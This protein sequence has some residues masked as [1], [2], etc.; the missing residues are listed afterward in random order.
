MSPAGASDRTQDSLGT[1]C[2]IHDTATREDSGR[3]PITP[4]AGRWR[5]TIPSISRWTAPSFGRKDEGIDTGT[6]IF[7]S[8][9]D[10]VEIRRIT[11]INR[12]VYAR[13]LALTSYVELA[14]A[15][16]NADLQHPAFQKIFIQTEAI[17][18]LSTL[19]A[20]RRPRSPEEPPM[21]VAHRFA[22]TQPGRRP[23]AI[24]NRPAPLHRAGKDTGQSDG[25]CATG[26]KQPGLR[27]GSHPEPPGKRGPGAGP[28][29]AAVPGHRRRRIARESPF[30]GGEVLAILSPSTGRWILT[31]P[32][33]SSNCGPCGSNPT[34]PAN[35]RSWPTIFC[36]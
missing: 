5:T 16:H 23:D 9:E 7:V 4:S 13:K 6:E 25:A 1:F 21:F 32:P 12:T 30:P 18:P 15:P 22:T 31:G 20:F 34:M 35:F 10:D 19:L 8:A 24:R 27:P 36:M 14:M 26:G 28:A 11:L 3:T 29:A 17:P 33:P 2:Y